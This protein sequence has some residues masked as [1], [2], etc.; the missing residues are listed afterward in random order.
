MGELVHTSKI[1]VVQEE[2]PLRL[3]YIEHFTE[4]VKYG[5]HTAI[6]DFYGVTPKEEHPSTLD[7]LIGAVGG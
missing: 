3:A 1:R 4:P 6:A 2:R 5:M 7:H